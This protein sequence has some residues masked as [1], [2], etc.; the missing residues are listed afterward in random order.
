MITRGANINPVVFD[1]LVKTAKDLKITYQVQASP[2][3]TGTDANVIQ[4]SR[5][6]VATGLV[7]VPLR[8]MHTPSEIINLDDIENAARLMAG[9]C[10]RVTTDID[11]TPA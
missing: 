8:Y 11:W 1:N 3:G 4:L 10:E 2:G 7:S 5:A 9:F 6:G